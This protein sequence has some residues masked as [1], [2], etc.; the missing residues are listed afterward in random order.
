ME[1]DLKKHGR[2]LFS[3]T[4]VW[5]LVE[6]KNRPQATPDVCAQTTSWLHPQ[7]DEARLPP[8]TPSESTGENLQRVESA[9]EGGEA[10]QHFY[11]LTW[12]SGVVDLN[13][14]LLLFF[15]R[16]LLACCKR[17]PR[18]RGACRARLVTD[19]RKARWGSSHMRCP[20]P[21]NWRTEELE[22]TF[23]L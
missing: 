19:L 17:R 20:R 21:M 6:R 4:S 5:A 22:N 15:S 10:K 8:R 2:K 9:Y 14:A 1:N 3:F 12:P 13:T 11:P 23:L 18:M 16:P 7:P